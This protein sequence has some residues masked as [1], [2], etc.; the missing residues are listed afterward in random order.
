MG[1]ED[2]VARLVEPSLN[3]MGYGLVRVRF[4]GGVRR[5]LQV[6]AERADGVE[7]TVEDCAS[8]SRELSAILDVEDP[9]PGPYTLEVSSPGIDRPLVRLED[10]R[11]FAG[12]EARVE[13]RVAI[14]GR[15]RF[16]GML[17]GVQGEGVLI[18]VEG[19]RLSIPHSGI[20]RAKLVLTD[21]L[22]AGVKGGG[23]EL[24]DS[25]VQT[26]ETEVCE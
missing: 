9:V 26:A 6:M 23:V 10:F 15:R 8:I 1:S 3:A 19:T 7:M 14:D 17:A 4:T 5:S 24:D 13:A 20:L 12:F 11:R 21:E 16:R 18:D 22:V 2:I 25:M